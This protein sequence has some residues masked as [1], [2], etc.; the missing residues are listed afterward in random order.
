[1]FFLVTNT[2]GKTAKIIQPRVDIAKVKCESDVR[3]ILNKTSAFNRKI[4]PTFYGRKMCFHGHLYQLD[5][6]FQLF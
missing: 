6:V 5:I 1:M 4:E 3:L 2:I